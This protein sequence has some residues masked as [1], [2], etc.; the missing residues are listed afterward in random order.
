MR[1]VLINLL[2]N[3]AKFTPSGGSVSA[4]ITLETDA[5]ITITV[6]DTG[7]GISAPEDIDKVV[8]PFGRLQIARTSKI[9]GTGLGLALSKAI[10]EAHGARLALIS[11]V[12]SGTAVSVHLPADRF[13]ER[14]IARCCENPIRI[15]NPAHA[16]DEYRS[17]RRMGDHRSRCPPGCNP[18]APGE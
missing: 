11:E 15:G 13:V 3:A 5:A 12:G 18:V 9:D 2:S 7:I 6:R 16:G 1:Q 14:A 8:A 4:E 10:V 17:I